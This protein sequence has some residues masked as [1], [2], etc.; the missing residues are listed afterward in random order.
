[1]HDECCEGIALSLICIFH[2]CREL[3]NRHTYV[4]PDKKA[5][6]KAKETL[7]YNANV[8]DGQRVFFFIGIGMNT[9]LFTMYV[10]AFY[11]MR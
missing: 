11:D 10:K 7:F 9:T 3:A 1:M 4:N 8:L 6:N 5:I 2:R